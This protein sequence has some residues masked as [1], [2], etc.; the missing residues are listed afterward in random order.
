MAGARKEK[1]DFSDEELEEIMDMHA[2]K[3]QISTAELRQT[4]RENPLL[5]AGLVFTFGLLLGISFRPS[6]RR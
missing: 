2:P 5:V 4:I 3:G 1:E 6:R